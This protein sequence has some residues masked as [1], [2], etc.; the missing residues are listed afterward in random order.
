MELPIAV[1]RK[2]PQRL[3]PARF[4]P[5]NCNQHLYS[6]LQ[7]IAAVCSNRRIYRHAHRWNLIIHWWL[8]VRVIFCALSRQTVAFYGARIPYLKSS[9]A[10]TTT[11]LKLYNYG[12]IPRNLKLFNNVFHEYFKLLQKILN[13]SNIALHNTNEATINLIQRTK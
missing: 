13:K 2:V 1:S 6:A 5:L 12:G 9:Q 7:F 10:N 8:M 3:F 11:I 4:S